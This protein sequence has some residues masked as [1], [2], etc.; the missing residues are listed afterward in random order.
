M[1]K[2]STMNEK[3]RIL[4]RYNIWNGHN[5][6][7]GF[8]RTGYTRYLASVTGN[9]LIKV[10]VGQRRVGKSYL[11]RQVAMDLVRQ[12]VS[13]R[14]IFI[15]NKEIEDFSFI[16]TDK[17]LNTLFHLYESEIKP[18]GKVYIFID[19]VQNIEGW[20]RFVNSYSQDYMHK[21]ELFITGSNSRMLSGELATLLSGRYVQIDVHPFSYEEFIGYFNKKR[22]RDSYSEYLHTSG[23]PELYR[24]DGDEA[25]RNYVSSL[26]DTVMLHDIVSRNNIRDVQMLED[27]FVYVVNNASNLISIGNIV[28]YMKSQDRKVS[29]DTLSLYLQFMEQA[30]LIF[31]VNRYNIRGKSVIGGTVKFYANDLAF[32]NYLYRGFGYGDGYLLENAVYMEMRRL[33]FDLYVGNIDDREVD[34]VGIKGDRRVYIQV[35]YSLAGKETA[36]REYSSLEII[37]D[38]FEKY[39]VTMDDYP[40][41]SNNGIRNIQAWQLDEVLS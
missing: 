28:K 15:L 9:R 6:D 11:L 18:E 39:V 13:P 33:G 36:R 38:N 8:P 30:Y 21:Y 4:E 16:K 5:P 23:M 41:P 10:L 17:D 31:H 7:L 32:H 29:Y 3:I 25:R 35:T 37:S 14:N 22:G 1:Q 27:L 19:E 20:E 2:Y 26:K 40:Q 24:L 12:G 34:F